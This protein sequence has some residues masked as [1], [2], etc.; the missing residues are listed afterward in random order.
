MSSKKKIYLSLIF[1]GIISLLFL[2]LI[3]PHFLGEIR[4]NSENLVSS[5]NELISLQR[6]IKNLKELKITYQT[7]QANLAKID[8]IFID[9][10]APIE[11]I[12]FLEK[13]AQ[14]SQ[15]KIEISLV[16][17]KEAEDELWPSLFFQI[18]TFGSSPKFLKFSEKLENSPYLIEVLNLNIK[19]LTEREIQSAKFQGLSLGDVKSTFLIKVFVKK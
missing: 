1:F 18:S 19:K 2:F 11:F 9:S 6:E 4:K 17:K 5:K 13:N 12:D 14:I 7:S 3:I 15:Q 10:E 8:E 16:S